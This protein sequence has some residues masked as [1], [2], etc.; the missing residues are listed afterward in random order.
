VTNEPVR[1]WITF[2][3]HIFADVFARLLQK[4]DSVEV[5]TDSMEVADV[6]VLPIDEAGQPALYLLPQPLPE[7]KL[8]AISPRGDR[9]LVRL[10]GKRQWREVCPFSLR[11]LFAEVQASSPRRQAAPRREAARPGW[12]ARTRLA[13]FLARIAGGAPR[14]Q[15]AGRTRWV[16]IGLALASLLL[17]LGLTTSAVRASADSLPGEPLYQ[18]KRLSE[19]AQLALS[20]ETEAPAL[21]AEFAGRRLAEIEALAEQGVILPEVVEDMSASTRAA[22]S[23]APGVSERH[24]LYVTLAVLTHRQQLVLSALRTRLPPEARPALEAALEISAEH[25]EAAMSLAQTPAGAPGPNPSPSALASATARQRAAST[26]TGPDRPARTSTLIP[27]A[28]DLPSQTATLLPTRPPVIRETPTHTLP[29]TIWPTATLL[30]TETPSE[31]P[32]P[33]DTPMAT[34]TPTATQ[35]AAPT[36]TL[37]ATQTAA[38]SETLTATQTAAPTETPSPTPAPTETLIAMPTATEM[39]SPT[40]APTATPAPTQLPAAPASHTAAAPGAPQATQ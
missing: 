25:Q 32:A 15:N 38:P 13:E 26:H 20:A 21:Q 18:V 33:T 10:P 36:E 28:T 30:L 11:D 16:Q 14:F 27:T 12:P 22:L 24:K 19:M 23:G 37:T 1:V 31:T 6:I 5:V 9:G 40:P 7:A 35:T 8:I 2:E 3:P 29:P 4:L 39:T 17:I 34:E